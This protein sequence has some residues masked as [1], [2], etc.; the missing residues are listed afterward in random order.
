MHILITGGTGFLGSSLAKNFSRNNNIS[1]IARGN[2]KDFLSKK[3]LI[4][5]NFITCDI[6]NRDSLQKNLSSKIDLV[7][8]CAGVMNTQV[9][10]RCTTGLI[11]TNLVATKNLIETM[12]NKGIKKI[13]FSSSMTVYSPRSR[14][15]V[16]ENSRL[17]PVHFYGMSKKWAEEMLSGYAQR[18]LIKALILRYP[19]I[20]GYPRKSGYIHNITRKLLRNED[21]IIDT[22]G[23]KFWET[24]NIEDAADITK[25][26]VELE[27]PEN[28][29]EI[30]N[31]SYGEETDF[32]NTAFKI[33]KIVNSKSSVKIKKSLDYRKFYLNNSKLR[34]LIDFNYNFEKGLS[35]FL[36][37]YENWI[38]K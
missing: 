38:R 3:E 7:I 26:V 4:K 35:F 1:I 9:A 27:M 2:E 30:V 34:S 33:K 25:R 36:K 29:C 18:G 32:I 24:I 17:E 11:E 28:D 13:V 31:C 21:V 10:S 20:Y 19:G 22:K 5:F 14:V 15:P 8:H 6:N 16:S 23:L 37:S 12:I